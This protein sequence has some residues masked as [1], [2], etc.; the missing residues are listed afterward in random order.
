MVTN[1]MTVAQLLQM[2]ISLNKLQSFV[3]KE[4]KASK[5]QAEKEQRAVEQAE[6]ATKVLEVLNSD[7]A[8]KWKTGQL[9][10][11]I[12]GIKKSED[13]IQEDERYRVHG[14]ISSSL[15]DMSELGTINK[16]QIG[17]NACHTYYQST[18]PVPEAE[19][20][21]ITPVQEETDSLEMM[22][23]EDW[24]EALQD[25]EDLKEEIQALLED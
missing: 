14:L 8:K 6:V 15:K 5:R 1:E 12:F 4:L 20:S 13:S 16:V 25:E 10:E 3:E 11:Q 7:P 2:G 21:V 17:A 24:I 19:F 18:L 9:V 23:D 22:S